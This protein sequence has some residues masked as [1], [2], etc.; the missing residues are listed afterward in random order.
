MRKAS[1]EAEKNF[2]VEKRSRIIIGKG[3]ARGRARGAVTCATRRPE[4]SLQERRAAPEQKQC[5]RGKS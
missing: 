1:E 5:S 2:S 4:K 3:I